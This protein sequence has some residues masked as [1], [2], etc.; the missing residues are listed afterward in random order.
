MNH[1]AMPTRIHACMS[2]VCIIYHTPPFT[3]FSLNNCHLRCPENVSLAAIRIG[4][5]KIAAG[6]KYLEF[7]D[8]S[9]EWTEKC[10]STIVRG[11]S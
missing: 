11:V 4:M 10:W 3:V 5:N 9:L 1:L 2:S 8:E 6:D 7:I